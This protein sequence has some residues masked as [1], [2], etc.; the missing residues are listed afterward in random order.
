MKIGIHNC[1]SLP[2]FSLVYKQNIHSPLPLFSEKKERGGT[3]Y[4]QNLHSPL[5]LFSEKKERSGTYIPGQ[6]G[7]R[8]NSCVGKDGHSTAHNGIRYNAPIFYRHIIP[9]VTAV[10]FHIAT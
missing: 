8:L 2:W 6:N 1:P 10:Q 5:P 9:N 7:V 3:Y 4:T